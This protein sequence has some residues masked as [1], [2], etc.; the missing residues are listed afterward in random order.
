VTRL[1]LGRL[2]AGR[3]RPSSPLEL[4]YAIVSALAR[5]MAQVV[6][7]LAGTIAT[8]ERRILDQEHKDPERIL[9][10]LFQVRHE[11]LTVRT[12]AGQSREIYGRMGAV[13]RSCLP[14]RGRS[15][16]TSWTSSR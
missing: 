7:T 14:R 16:R 2:Q 10:E 12:M 13:A 11:L 3:L 1:V 6:G 9:H 8:L 5:G 15:S 4:S